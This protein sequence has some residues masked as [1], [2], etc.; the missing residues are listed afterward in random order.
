MP[1]PW[2]SCWSLL[3]SEDKSLASCTSTRMTGNQQLGEKTPMSFRPGAKALPRQSDIQCTHCGDRRRALR[4]CSDHPHPAVFRPADARSRPTNK[5][6]I[7]G[8]TIGGSQSDRAMPMFKTGGDE[9]SGCRD[10]RLLF[11]GF[12]STHRT[13]M[14][15]A[16]Q[17]LCTIRRC[18][19]RP[20]QR[21]LSTLL[22]PS[23]KTVCVHIPSRSR[24][25]LLGM[26]DLRV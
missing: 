17:N 24:R 10:G 12:L 9:E 3:L 2:V 14:E 20:R 6:M 1:A 11:F 25:A 22:P 4:S 8:Q 13:A 18:V 5:A 26:Q 16:C 23:R 19:H 7:R 21:M 15:A